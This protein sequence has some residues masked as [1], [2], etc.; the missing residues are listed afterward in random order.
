MIKL[1]TCADV[2]TTQET[3]TGII[4]VNQEHTQVSTKE[5]KQETL[6]R[7]TLKIRKLVSLFQGNKITLNA[8]AHKIWKQKI[9][10]NQ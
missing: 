4:V 8:L 1:W 2:V 7:C 6:G 5:H 3:K 10:N 9:K